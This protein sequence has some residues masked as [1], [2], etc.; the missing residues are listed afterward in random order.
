MQIIVLD[1]RLKVAAEYDCS[2]DKTILFLSPEDGGENDTPSQNSDERQ[3]EL[4]ERSQK[5]K[6][7][8]TRSH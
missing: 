3:G 7:K 5:K 4:F 1:G 8:R 2:I 6:K